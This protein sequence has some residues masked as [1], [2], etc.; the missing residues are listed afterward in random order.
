MSIKGKHM[1]QIHRVAGLLCMA[2]LLTGCVAD[3]AYRQQL[4]VLHV[5]PEP[6]QL[7]TPSSLLPVGAP[8]DRDSDKLTPA[9]DLNGRKIEHSSGPCIAFIEFNDQGQEQVPTSGS[10]PGQLDRALSL[11]KRA[12]ADDPQH[13]PVIL[14][15]IHGWKHNDSPGQ[16]HEPDASG[17]RPAN[18][19]YPED[20]NIQGFE[21]VLDYLYTDKYGGQ[22]CEGKPLSCK[23]AAG[24]VVVGVYLSWRGEIISHDWPV[25]RTLSLYSRGNAATRVGSAR[26]MDNALDQI[27]LTAHPPGSE[28]SPTQPMLV[29]I[30]HSFGARVLE[31][32]VNGLYLPRLKNA[33]A[34]N[35]ESVPTFADLILLV[36]SAASST[37]SLPLLNLFAEKRIE[38]REDSS[39]GEAGNGL[40]R[41][42]PLVLSLTTPTDSAT[43]TLFPIA[44]GADGLAKKIGGKLKPAE[45]MHCFDPVTG[46]PGEDHSKS[47]YYF[48]SHTAAHTELLQ[49]H[50]VTDLGPPSKPGDGATCPKNSSPNTYDYYVPGHCFRVAPK[51]P[52]CS[53]DNYANDTPYWIINTDAAIIPDHGTIFTDRLIGLIG[54]FLPQST[55]RVI[56]TPR[57]STPEQRSR[58]PQTR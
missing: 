29:F 42:R 21:H 11:I 31:N 18:D 39:S 44:M 19:F 28:G 27:S 43:G 9:R 51:Q 30:G 54:E 40:G 25:A 22:D 1:K 6:P 33:V 37:V 35:G 47:E 12:I 38:Y 34:A 52:G 55:T 45:T 10:T 15:F 7:P 48:Y 24:H 36:N 17:E 3:R 32:A 46:A 8:C 2:S 49:S 5:P 50:T 58:K 26:R 13:Q 20:S 23:A 41:N 14:T 57:L 53:K 16:P 4:S 56:Q